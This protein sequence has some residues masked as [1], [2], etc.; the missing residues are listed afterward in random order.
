MLFRRPKDLGDERLR[1]IRQLIRLEPEKQREP[2]GWRR[3]GRQRVAKN[4]LHVGW[5]QLGE[6]GRAVR[7]CQRRITFFGEVD[8]PERVRHAG[9]ARRI[10]V[11]VRQQHD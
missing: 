7:S 4:V 10:G 2:S 9:V 3:Q 6:N 11:R 5:A 1:L 8:G